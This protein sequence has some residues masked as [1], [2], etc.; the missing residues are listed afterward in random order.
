[1]QSIEKALKNVFDY[2]GDNYVLPTTEFL[3]DDFGTIHK[4]RNPYFGQNPKKVKF[5][6]GTQI[7]LNIWLTE[8]QDKYPLVWLVYPLKEAYNNDGSVDYHY[9]NARLIFAMNNDADKLVNT[10]VQTTRYVL[11]QLTANFTKLMQVS[12]FRKYLNIDQKQNIVETFEPNYSVR[13]NGRESITL[14]IWDAI[15]FD[16]DLRFVPKCMNK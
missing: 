9:K 7:E 11:S 4:F 10:R 15:T 13:N 1:M 8:T 16:C 6:F 12:K 5:M 3:A 14:D 2:I